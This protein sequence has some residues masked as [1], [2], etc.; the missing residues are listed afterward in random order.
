MIDTDLRLLPAKCDDLSPYR[1]GEDP[2]R[3]RVSSHHYVW[4]EQ[5][6]DMF[7]RRL[8]SYSR[9]VERTDLRRRR[10]RGNSKICRLNDELLECILLTKTR[11]K[12]ILSSLLSHTGG[13]DHL[14]TGVEK[15]MS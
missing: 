14:D 9:V 12:S 8:H 7:S 4:M 1:V 6:L 3:R 5:V 11:L 13:L 10:T 2:K 15:M